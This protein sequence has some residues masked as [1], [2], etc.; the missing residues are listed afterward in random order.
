LNLD[1]FEEN[2]EQVLFLWQRLLRYLEGELKH[3]EAEAVVIEVGTRLEARFAGRQAYFPA[4]VLKVHGSGT[5]FD[6][7]YD[8]TYSQTTRSSK[9]DGGVLNRR[10]AGFSSSLLDNGEHEL[11][12]PFALLRT[13]PEPPRTPREDG[14]LRVIARLQWTLRLGIERPVELAHYRRHYMPPIAPCIT[15]T[16]EPGST[17]VYWAKQEIV[18][19]RGLFD[20]NRTDSLVFM[21]K[22]G[23]PD[24]N[25]G[26]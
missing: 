19:V 2:S 18:P 11:R 25:D 6:L 21:G 20:V 16:F 8:S 4:T 15:P 22:Y 13:Y 17:A 7:K 26:I 9:G 5:F 14:L 24:T 3:R 10:E 23:E 12:V 1:L